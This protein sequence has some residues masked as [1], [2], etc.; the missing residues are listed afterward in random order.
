MT[1]VNGQELSILD[2][3]NETRKA[4]YH[5][6][7]GLDSSRTNVNI[8]TLKQSMKLRALRLI[9]TS[10]RLITLGAV[11]MGSNLGVFR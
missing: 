11:V 6:S 4:N 3:W 10:D 8:L 5:F 7:S 2:H 1:D 9:W